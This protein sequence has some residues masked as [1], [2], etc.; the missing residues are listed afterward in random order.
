MCIRHYYLGTSGGGRGS[1][2]CG[3]EVSPEGPVLKGPTWVHSP[4]TQAVGVPVVLKASVGLNLL[5][6]YLGLYEDS[7]SPNHPVTPC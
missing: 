4:R 1:R 6:C 7:L 2:G 3:T 5:A